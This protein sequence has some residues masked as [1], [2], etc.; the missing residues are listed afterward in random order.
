MKLATERTLPD[1]A[2]EAP[3]GII[4]AREWVLRM[5]SGDFATRG[6]A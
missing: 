5:L 1:A 4:D 6:I 2:R 3:W